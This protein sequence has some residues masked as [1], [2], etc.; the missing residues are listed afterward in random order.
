MRGAR[1]VLG[2]V[3][4]CPHTSM[5]IPALCAPAGSALL[6][7]ALS[8]LGPRAA[9]IRSHLRPPRKASDQVLRLRC[10]FIRVV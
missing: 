8:L 1:V 2:L 10:F 9:T 7:T 3:Q 6:P 5:C 4:D